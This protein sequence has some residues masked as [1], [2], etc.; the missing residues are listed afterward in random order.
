M[1]LIRLLIP[2]LAATLG[3]ALAVPAGADPIDDRA[4]MDRELAAASAQLEVASKR[5]QQAAASYAAAVAAIPGARTALAEAQGRVAAAEAGVRRAARDVAAARDV[6][7]HADLEHVDAAAQVAQARE[8]ISRFATITYKG[9]D[10]LLLD[11]VIQSGSVAEFARRMGYLDRVAEER[12]TALRGLVEARARAR[13]RRAEA[14]AASRRAQELAMSAERALARGRAAAVEAA[15]A[16]ARVRDLVSQREAAVAVANAERGAVVARYEEL[17]AE[18]AR[19][20]ARLRAVGRRGGNAGPPTPVEPRAGAFFLMPV[21]GHR[22]GGFGRR[23]HPL[24]HVWLMH[25]GLDIGA[26]VGQPIAATA[27]GQVVRAGWARGYGNL[28]CISHGQHAGRGLATCYAHQSQILV[29]DG[30]RVRRGQMIGRVGSTGNST[31]PHLHF[32][33]RVAGSPV[34]PEK[35]LPACLC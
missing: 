21:Q 8:R 4:R 24:F 15:R 3:L 32:E 5:A 18:S 26:G 29:Q 19:I 28:T 12:Q 33:V 10:L 34:D 11:S 30:Q 6:Q 16:D 17:K 20:E 27:D 7:S 14:E 2:T 1:R 23:F 22:S 31:G 25:T 35:W 13:D 9:G